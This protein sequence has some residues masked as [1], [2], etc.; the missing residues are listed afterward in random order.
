MILGHELTLGDREIK[1]IVKWIS[2][3]IGTMSFMAP[4]QLTKPVEFSRIR[5]FGRPPITWQ[6]FIGDCPSCA[7]EVGG[8]WTTS[9][10]SLFPPKVDASAPANIASLF[11]GVGQL[12]CFCVLNA[13]GLDL[14]FN[15]T[16]GRVPPMVRIWPSQETE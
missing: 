16:E 3:T 4:K 10:I 2:K 1:I 15:A 11:F 9:H 8:H 5:R 6:L 7:G 12:L 13:S 14:D